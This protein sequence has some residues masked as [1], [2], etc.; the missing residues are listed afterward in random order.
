MR[1]R[2]PFAVFFLQNAA[3]HAEG[4]RRLCGGAGFGDDVHRNILAF[5]QGNDALQVGRADGIAHKEN[6]RRAL[7]RLV[8]KA[9]LQRLNNRA[10]PK[11]AAAN[12]NHHQ[13][14]AV[15]LYFLCRRL[16]A[17]KLFFI[18]I[19]R[20]VYPAK[21]NRCPGR[22]SSAMSRAPGPPAEKWLKTRR[23]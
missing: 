9:A 14:L 18:V 21:G 4:Q 16:D 23:R 6:L 5:A 2:A 12:A 22:F 17:G 1:S 19:F 11:V 8:V 15:L 13:H 10:G 7:A 20:Q 3:E